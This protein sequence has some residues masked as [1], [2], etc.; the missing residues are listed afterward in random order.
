MFGGVPNLAICIGYVNA[1]WTLRADLVSRYVCRLLEHL[2]ANGLRW[3]APNPPEGMEPMPLL[4]LR[5]GY[6]RR[7][8]SQMP[9]QGD[10][11]PWLMRQN[12]LLDR[13]EMI[14]RRPHGG[15]D[16]RTLTR[17]RSAAALSPG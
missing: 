17:R 2:D 10:A 13:R 5:S 8:E 1:S 15:D 9:Q 14:R 4:P 7:A 12:Y 3:A 16:L 11:A 6:L